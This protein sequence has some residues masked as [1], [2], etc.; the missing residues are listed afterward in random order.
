[1]K[2]LEQKLRAASLHASIPWALEQ[3]GRL[4]AVEHTWEENATVVQTTE[5]DAE[6][7]AILGALGIRLG[8]P[9]L[10]VSPA[11]AA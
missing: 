5:L 4:K 11:A 6:L 10:R 7:K 1:A 3:L 9:V 8:N 2:T